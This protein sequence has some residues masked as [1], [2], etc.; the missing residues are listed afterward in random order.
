[1]R[2]PFCGGFRRRSLIARSLCA[3]SSNCDLNVAGISTLRHERGWRCRGLCAPCTFSLPSTPQIQGHA[4]VVENCTFFC[5]SNTNYRFH[6]PSCTA[7]YKRVAFCARARAAQAGRF[8]L[9]DAN[10]W[11]C[12]TSQGCYG[13]LPRAPSAAGSRFPLVNGCSSFTSNHAM[14]LAV[15]TPG[16]VVLRGVLSLVASALV[17]VAR[18]KHSLCM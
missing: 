16:L 15:A 5:V 2:P 13:V 18:D 1:M 3:A 4:A 12:R 8:A 6:N 17:C 14:N 7:H 9:P 11:G 10:W